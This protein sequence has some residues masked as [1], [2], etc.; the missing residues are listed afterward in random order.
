MA[1]QGNNIGGNAQANPYADRSSGSARAVPPQEAPRREERQQSEYRNPQ[2]NLASLINPLPGGVSRSAGGE[3]LADTNAV[4]GE[5]VKNGTWNNGLE[6]R[7]FPIDHTAVQTLKISAMVVAVRI[8]G[9]L[10]AG[11]AYH[12][13]I[14]AASAG[15]IQAKRLKLEGREVEMI[16]TADNGNDAVMQETVEKLIASAY[17][18]VHLV[19]V[20]STT[21][22]TT[23]NLKDSTQMSRLLVNGLLGCITYLQEIAGEKSVVSLKE[24]C[25][26]MR[27]VTALSFDHTKLV[28]D[29]QL[30]VRN[31]F[32]ITLSSNPLVS[33]TDTLGLNDGAEAKEIM[34]VSGYV[35]VAWTEGPAEQ[36]YDS[37]RPPTTARYIPQI[38]ATSVYTGDPSYI[39]L[40]AIALGMLNAL[41]NNTA[42]MQAMPMATK[43]GDLS[44]YGILSMETPI[45]PQ[46]P[47]NLAA[48]PF[49]SDDEGR[50]AYHDFL[51]R[52][53][54]ATPQICV[55]VPMCGPETWQLGFLMDVADGDTDARL[56][57]IDT[58]NQLTDDRFGAILSADDWLVRLDSEVHLGTYRNAAGELRDIREIGYVQM[59]NAALPLGNGPNNPLQVWSASWAERDR[60]IALRLDERLR[61]QTAFFGQMNVTGMAQRLE[62]STGFLDG[63]AR[64]FAGSSF[65]PVMTGFKSQLDSYSRAGFRGHTMAAG[66]AA[67]LF[68]R[69]ST[70]DRGSSASRYGSRS[71]RYSHRG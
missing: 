62:F 4:L 53:V 10:D 70:E 21:V 25:T 66:H 1:V 27:F 49:R 44:D 59:A 47:R 18:G 61:T 3:A 17:P 40:I 7:L 48:T 12:T 54:L 43:P 8:K 38:I 60:D 28:N 14:L 13:M 63:I 50:A 41:R 56:M 16:R 46:N 58:I 55:D 64:A 45:D 9:S 52:M 20:P 19:P 51:R 35:D 42:W 65:H 30:P 69:P 22:P 15:V 5:L 26:H 33:T 24:M 39:A 23:V 37:R 71:N 68:R 67:E 2:A 29:A 31:D 57:L 6:I 32:T 11:V 36:D 34:N